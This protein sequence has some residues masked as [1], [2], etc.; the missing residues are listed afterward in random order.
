MTAS[1]ARIEANAR[2]N[3]K[4]YE[5]IKIQIRKELRMQELLEIACTQTGKSKAQYITEAIQTQLDRDGI[6]P[7]VLPDQE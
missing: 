5:Q 6:T 4:T 3:A 2:Y 1:K 7:D